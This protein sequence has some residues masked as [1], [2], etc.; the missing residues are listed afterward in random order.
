MAISQKYFFNL[1]STNYKLLSMNNMDEI[2]FHDMQLVNDYKHAQIVSQC[3]HQDFKMDK[4]QVGR[5]DH[6]RTAVHRADYQY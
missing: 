1:V 3:R 5:F 4:S 6:S 2:M